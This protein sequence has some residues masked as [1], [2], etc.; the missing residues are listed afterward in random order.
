MSEQARGVRNE[1]SPESAQRLYYPTNNK[2]LFETLVY[3]DEGGYLPRDTRSG[4]LLRLST[5]S[6][7]IICLRGSSTGSSICYRSLGLQRF[8]RMS[9]TGFD[10]GRGG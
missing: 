2:D 5:P 10:F 3:Y 1:T 8:K 4:S 9:A 6:S 7:W